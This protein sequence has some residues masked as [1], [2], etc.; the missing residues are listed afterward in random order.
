MDVA[1]KMENL[2]IYTAEPAHQEVISDSADVKEPKKA[3]SKAE[4]QKVQQNLV[5]VQRQIA[6]SKNGAP[7]KQLLLYLVRWVWNQS[8]VTV[9]WSVAITDLGSLIDFDRIFH[10]VEI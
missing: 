4:F 6:N 2:S 7:P 1:K 8:T 5:A 9:K 3:L 10:N